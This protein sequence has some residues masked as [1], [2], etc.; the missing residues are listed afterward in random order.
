MEDFLPRQGEYRGNS[1]GKKSKADS[2]EGPALFS[3][4]KKRMEEEKANGSLPRDLS[5]ISGGG[6][7]TAGCVASLGWKHFPFR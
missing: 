2:R 7:G 6:G 3:P 1:L 4:K 5:R